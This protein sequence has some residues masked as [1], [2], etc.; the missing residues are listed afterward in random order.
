MK[1]HYNDITT[2][3]IFI[4][5]IVSSKLIGN[6][7]SMVKNPSIGKEKIK[8]KLTPKRVWIWLCYSNMSKL[9][10]SVSLE[11]QFKPSMA[12]WDHHKQKTVYL[13]KYENGVYLRVIDT[14]IVPVQLHFSRWMA[15]T[16]E[17]DSYIYI[18]DQAINCSNI[19]YKLVINDDTSNIIIFMKNNKNCTISYIME[20]ITY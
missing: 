5:Y 10:S 8:N 16:T 20:R 4:V 11:E 14:L 15:I 17:N 1:T 3:F 19:E 7:F 18:I 2:H 6:H 12:S 9:C 13:Q